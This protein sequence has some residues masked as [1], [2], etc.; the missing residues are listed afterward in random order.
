M[1]SNFDSTFVYFEKVPPYRMT[2]PFRPTNTLSFVVTYT[3]RVLRRNVDRLRFSFLPSDTAKK[4]R[5]CKTAYFYSVC[6]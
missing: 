1:E 3:D 2:K 5:M 6:H 4:I